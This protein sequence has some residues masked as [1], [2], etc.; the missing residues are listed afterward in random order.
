M[1][2]LNYI[3]VGTNRLA[4]AKAFYDVLL[5]S[6]GIATLFDL[7]E[8]GRMYGSFASFVFG[9]LSPY[10]RQ[11]A[12]PGNGS[13]C[14]FNLDSP[15]EVDAFYALALQLGGTCEGNPGE[16]GAEGAGYYFAYVRDLD[17]NKLC[18]YHVRGA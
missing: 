2:R 4:E 5:G 8:G 11:S 12:T 10:D 16:R 3:T 18:A 15:A 17:G 7:S 1:T 13:M 9:V 6:V 14:G